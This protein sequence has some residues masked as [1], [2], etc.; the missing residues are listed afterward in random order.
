MFS[1]MSMSLEERMNEF[2]AHKPSI[3]PTAFVAPTS[4]II[5]HVTLEEESSIW[6]QTVLRADINR[7]H[8]G[9]HSNIQDGSVVHLADDYPVIIGEWV[10]IG[11][12]AMIH[13]CTIDNEVLVGMGAIIL[14]G[15]EIGARSIIGAG[16]VVTSGMKVPPGSLVLGTPGKVVKTLDLDAQAKVRTWAEKYVGVAKRF[17]EHSRETP[18]GVYL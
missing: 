7:I 15:A 6:Y 12:K 4:A 2:F 8:V 5:G 13:A 10:T 3:H 14:D 9:A 18:Q 1:I 11:H 17:L 16:A